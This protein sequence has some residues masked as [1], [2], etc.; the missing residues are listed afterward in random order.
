VRRFQLYGV[1]LCAIIVVG[2]VLDDAINRIRRHERICGAKMVVLAP[3]AKRLLFPPGDLSIETTLRP[4]L[5]ISLSSSSISQS[6]WFNICYR[7]SAF[8]WIFMQ[9]HIF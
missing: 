6:L 7:Q 1:A 2:V 5:R 4:I 8:S 3:S 9:P